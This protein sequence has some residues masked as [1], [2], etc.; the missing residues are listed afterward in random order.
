MLPYLNDDSSECRVI[1]IDPGSHR[2]LVSSENG[3]QR[4]MRVEIP[5]KTRTG[6]QLQRALREK[7]S[8]NAFIL[9]ILGCGRMPRL[10]L[11]EALNDERHPD[12]DNVSLDRLDPVDLSCEE[13]CACE[14]FLANGSTF[15]RIGWIDEAIR[16]LES[17]TKRSFRKELIAQWNAGTGFVLARFESH[18]GAGYW[19]KA[20]GAPNEHELSV[21]KLLSEQC[22]QFLPGMIASKLQWNAWITQDAGKPVSTALGS[23]PLL[24][25]VERFAALQLETADVVNSLIEAGASDHRAQALRDALDPIFAFLVD[26]MGRQ[27][28]TKAERLERR[29]IVELEQILLDVLYQLEDLRMPDTLLHNDLNAG[30]ILFDGKQCVFIDW[31]EAAVG[32]P[33]L[34]AE[35]F[36]LLEG[37]PASECGAIFRKPWRELIREEEICRAERLAPLVSTLTY[38]YG[39]GDWLKDSSKVTPQFES[40]ARSLARHMNRAAQSTEL[41]EALCH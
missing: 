15:L 2:I 41:R 39:R 4:L 11:A 30:N 20:T 31:S 40:Y 24:N 6:Q 29:Q 8:V 21:T 33:F 22:S 1:L 13:R 19:I 3:Q 37:M 5:S 26:A 10:V 38:L 14:R 28:S 16:W 17:A 9:E 12:L 34:C 32:N 27:T 35:R 25:G 36:R 7:W 23:A 18:D